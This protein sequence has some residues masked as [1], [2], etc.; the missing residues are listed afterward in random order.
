MKR[1]Y[2]MAGVSENDAGFLVELD[3]RPVRTPARKLLA[4]PSRNLAEALGAEN[5]PDFGNT[6]NFLPHFG[7]QHA[8]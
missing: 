5:I 8:G 2:K 6:N 1:F 7:R 4:T 3:G